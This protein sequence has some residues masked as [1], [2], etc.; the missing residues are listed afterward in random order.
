[1]RR[2]SGASGRR[3]FGRGSTQSL[4]TVKET[5]RVNGQSAYR[6][7][8]V[9]QDCV[10][11]MFDGEYYILIAGSLISAEAERCT[12]TWCFAYRHDNHHSS[13]RALSRSVV[14]MREDMEKETDIQTDR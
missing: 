9:P 5:A 10:L 13:T 12:K 4:W 1:M 11:F 6:V 2:R 8:P 14:S 7:F 3:Q